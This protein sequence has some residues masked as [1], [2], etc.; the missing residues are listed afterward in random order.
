VWLPDLLAKSASHSGTG[1]VETLEEHTKN[2]VV[3]LVGLARRSPN[4]PDLIAQPNLWHI[5]FWACVIHDFGKAMFD[6]QQTLRGIKPK[7]RHRHEVVSLAF[8]PWIVNENEQKLLEL[9]IVSHHRD[10][11]FITDA[12]FNYDL[13]ILVNQLSDTTVKGLAEWIV[14][15]PNAW[16][17]EMGFSDFSVKPKTFSIDLKHWNS[18]ACAAIQQGLDTYAKVHEGRAVYPDEPEYGNFRRERQLMMILRGIITQADRMA[19]A[20]AELAGTLELPSLEQL[21]LQLSEREGKKIEPRAHQISA[22]RDGN[23]ILMAPTGSGKTEA[24]LG[25]AAVQQRLSDGVLLPRRLIYVLPYQASLNAMQKRLERDLKIEQVAILHS[26]ALQ[27]LY[28]SLSEDKPNDEEQEMQLRIET[29]SLAETLETEQKPDPKEIT[30][31]ARKQNDFNR[32]H[33]P[34]VAVMTPYQMLRGAYRL[35]GYEAMFTMLAGATIVLDEIHAYEPI[36]LGMFLALTKELV[37][38]WGA[39]V[40]AMTAT[41][42]SWLRSELEDTLGVQALAPDENLFKASRRHKLQLLDA[43]LEHPETIN[44]IV[45]EVEAGRSVLVAANTVKK[46]QAVWGVLK[47]RLGKPQTLLLHS[48]FTGKD[49]LRL[50]TDLQTRLDARTGSSEAIAVVAT[51]V[52]EVSLDLDFDRIYTEPAPLEALVQRFGRV[53]RRGQKNELGRLPEGQRGIVPVTVLT[54]PREGQRVYENELIERGLL[55]LENT[56]KNDQLE[57]DDLL[58]AQWLDAVYTG[59]LLKEFQGVAH[60]SAKEFFESTLEKLH[61]FDS[62]KTLAQKFDA[63]FDGIQV[64]PKCFQKTYEELT[65]TSPIEA[66]GYLVNAP[67]WITGGLRDRV[68]W[69]EDLKLFIA[70]LPYSEE[71]GMQWKR[72]EIIHD[73]W[74]QKDD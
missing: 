19:S 25:W 2:V 61:A 46:A 22:A 44:K 21:A 69:N 31:R 48:R 3:A 60:K 13:T 49:R 16:I 72:P 6:F 64:L 73:S 12:Y 34:A 1:E 67:R 20:R 68:Q 24:A 41:M 39:R 74:G 23:I 36:R 4:L 11:G 59:D 29:E 18:T 8:L 32:L 17:E 51:Q 57:I 9:G 7:E 53:N 33:Q 5:A 10:K 58:V 45:L 65:K 55:Q 37:T 27:V 14:N 70:D 52:I 62:D 35:P 30:Q 71:I 56:V 54:Q 38:R 66:R 40:C 43:E 28:R 50:E 15:V 26:R 47:D 63:L 42:P